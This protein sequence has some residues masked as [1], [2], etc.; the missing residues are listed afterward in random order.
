ME[1]PRER[2]ETTLTRYFQL[3]DVPAPSGAGGPGAVREALS[4]LFSED[5]VWE[6]VGPAYA[7]KFGRAQGRKAVVAKVASFLPPRP[8]FTSTVHLLGQGTVVTDG[9]T[10]HGTW[11]LQQFSR[12]VSGE[13]ELLVA[14]LEVAF[15]L[16]EERT[17]ITHFRTE[18]MFRTPLS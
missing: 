14:R 10:A 11:P 8:H 17:L 3:C 12:Y 7:A 2:V 6:G 1:S 9:V 13:A 18:R 15:Y 16:S 4:A 5:A